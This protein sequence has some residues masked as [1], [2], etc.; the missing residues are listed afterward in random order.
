MILW[1]FTRKHG[2][3]P[4]CPHKFRVFRITRHGCAVGV[5]IVIMLTGSAVAGHAHDVAHV[6]VIVPHFVI[7]AFAYFAHGV[8]ALPVMVHLE[9][10]V[11]SLLEQPTTPKGE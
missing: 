10:L 5:G 2:D 8:G 4:T 7:D 11:K 6:L 9:P 1:L 3:A